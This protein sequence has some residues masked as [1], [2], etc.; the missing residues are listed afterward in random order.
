MYVIVYI[1]PYYSTVHTVALISSGKRSY[2]CCSFICNRIFS[3]STYSAVSPKPKSTPPC[4]PS[5]AALP[6]ACSTF[7]R[8]THC[9][10]DPLD[11]APLRPP[12]PPLPP[13]PDL[14]PDLPPPP[15]PPPPLPP[16]PPPPTFVL[17]LPP[18]LPTRTETHTQIHRHTDTCT[19]VFVQK[20]DKMR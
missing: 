6:P 9:A 8:L 13:D 12:V 3:L 10:L 19:Y 1:I 15:P 18:P 4:P 16:P 5:V 14:P 2:G 7:I 11:E 17:A 20:E